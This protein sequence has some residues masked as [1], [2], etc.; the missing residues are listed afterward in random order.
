VDIGN[1]PAFEQWQR[2]PQARLTRLVH[3]ALD[4]TLSGRRLLDGD[5]DAAALLEG[6]LDELVAALASW[7]GK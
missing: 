6:D 7:R 3:V 1:H 2:S 5:V 4:V